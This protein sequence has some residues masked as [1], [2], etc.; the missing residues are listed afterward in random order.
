MD[1]PGSRGTRTSSSGSAPARAAGRSHNADAARKAILDA[2][3]AVFAEH[4]FDGARVDVIAAQSGYN[5]SL[6]FQYF[7]D[8]LNLYSAVIRRADDQMR[9]MQDAIM[10][11]LLK[12]G[13]LNNPTRLKTMLGDFIGAFFDF[14]IANPSFLR[15]LNWELAEG[16]QTYQKILT[17]RDFQDLNDFEPVLT[18]VQ[19]YG[20]LRSQFNPMAQIVL[21][22]F[23]NST[24][25]GMLPFFKF[26][27]PGFDPQSGEAIAQAR[28]FIVEF[29]T[30]G[31]IADEAPPNAAK[32]GG[33][34]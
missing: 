1:E 4:G 6:I 23:V 8:K 27:L 3:E 13:T 31:L 25:L 11:E 34:P 32:P 29:I 20:L 7:G 15:I 33:I 26:F 18:K 14:M 2:A 19:Q 12:E 10:A 30:H 28:E 16:W 17:E 5:K 9:W 24:Y 21:A 22:N